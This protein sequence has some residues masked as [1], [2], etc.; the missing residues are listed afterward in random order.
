MKS[1]M[2]ITIDS[3]LKTLA[4][5][6][7]INISRAVNQYLDYKFAK[8]SDAEIK[9]FLDELRKID[10]KIIQLNAK[11][12]QLNA[13]IDQKMIEIFEKNEESARKLNES[14]RMA[15]ALKNARVLNDGI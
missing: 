8:E 15:D 11:K 9:K 7:N 14:V 4:K 6:N 12:A 5:I 13:K 1:N 10:E 2:M 3:R